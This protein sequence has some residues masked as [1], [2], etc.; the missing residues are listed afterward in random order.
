MSQELKMKMLPKLQARYERRNREGKSRMLDEFC[1]VCGYARKYAIG[2]LSRKPK[3]R[4]RRPGPRRRYGPEVLEPLKFLWLASEQMCSKRLKAALP[5]WLP[6][7]E[8][9]YGA[10][11]K[12]VRKKLLRISAATIDRL[13]SPNPKVLPHFRP[14]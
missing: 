14:I 13:L 12:P 7:Y 1:S 11:S 9:E 4:R 8:Q 2:L 5:L 6:F 10:L 3:Q